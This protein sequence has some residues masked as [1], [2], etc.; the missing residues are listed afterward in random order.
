MR[1]GIWLATRHV[2]PSL[3]GARAAM[4]AQMAC[5]PAKLRTSGTFALHGHAPTYAWHRVLFMYHVV[6]QCKPGNPNNAGPDLCQNPVQ[7][8]HSCPVQNGSQNISWFV[9]IENIDG[10]GPQNQFPNFGD[11]GEQ[12]ES[13]AIRENG[14]DSFQQ[15]SNNLQN[16]KHDKIKVNCLYD[17][18]KRKP[19][20]DLK[21]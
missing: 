8:H 21:L 17:K 15:T 18:K 3:V 19:P 20:Y 11:G 7:P 16:A 6:N 14:V 12:E 9:Q 10:N 2:R 1:M 5:L 4:V 13:H